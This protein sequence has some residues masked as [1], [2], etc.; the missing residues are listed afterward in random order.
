MIAKLIMSLIIGLLTIVLSVGI[1]ISI[2]V[3]KIR[4]RGK[5]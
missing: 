5:K 1:Y 2:A 4:K 3:E